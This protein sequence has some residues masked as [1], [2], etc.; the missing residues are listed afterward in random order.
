MKEYKQTIIEYIDTEYQ[1]LEDTKEYKNI[2]KNI[3][4]IVE[5][6][7]KKLKHINNLEDEIKMVW[8]I[9]KEMKENEL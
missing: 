9:V 1:G 8:D 2:I 7:Y 4:S 5:K 6:A 3:D